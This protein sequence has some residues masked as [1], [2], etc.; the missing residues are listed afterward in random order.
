MIDSRQEDRPSA[1]LRGRRALVEWGGP[2]T[3]TRTTSANPWQ[4]P[5]AR[6]VILLSSPLLSVIF[7]RGLRNRDR[8][9]FCAKSGGFHVTMLAQLAGLRL[10]VASWAAQGL[11]RSRTIWI[12]EAPP[13]PISPSYRT[14]AQ[15]RA[16]QQTSGTPCRCFPFLLSSRCSSIICHQEHTTPL[17][18]RT[19][20]CKTYR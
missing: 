10:G 20:K 15:A 12:C 1:Q 8:R 13:M 9:D 16:C 11:K 14:K 5:V 18:N 19:F 3:T 7:S 17:P 2:L 4:M 6:C